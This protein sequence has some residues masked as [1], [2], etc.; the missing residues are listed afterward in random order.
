MD[1]AIAT[2]IV[3][4]VIRVTMKIDN[5]VNMKEKSKPRI[6]SEIGCNH[7]GQ[8]DIALELI[9]L[10]KECGAD[11]AKFQKRTP[12]ELLTTESQRVIAQ[13]ERWPICLT[14]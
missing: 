7:M 13:R 6:I 4:R 12:K 11:Y 10:S 9:K 1:M 5:K 2:G 14:S 8:F 3:Q